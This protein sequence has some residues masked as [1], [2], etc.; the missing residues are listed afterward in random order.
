MP[1]I[2][3]S[4]S[5]QEFNPYIIGGTEEYYMNLIADAME[6][7]LY[8]TG[9][10]FTRNTPE[11]T[12]GSSIRASNAGNYDLHLSLHSNASGGTAGS[13]RGSEVYYYPTSQN[14][15]RAAE[16]IANNL[17]IIYPVPNGVRTIPTTTLGEV[18]RTRAPAV[19]IEFAYHDN[20]EDATWIANNIN[21]IAQNVVISLADYFGIPFVSP[22]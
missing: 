6:P 18:S 8:A 11:M 19:L 20:Y 15:R 10:D 1:S 12:A 3:L 2:Y 16:I 4:P 13:R 21:A 14:G 9:I 17:Q 7:Y 5:T 22:N